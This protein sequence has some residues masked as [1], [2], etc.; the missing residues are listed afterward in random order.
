VGLTLKARIESQ[1]PT[2]SGHWQ[3]RTGQWRNVH[4][5]APE[6]S[7]LPFGELVDVRI[8]DAGPHFLRGELA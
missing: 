4:L 8:V 3:A 7:R 5:R 2:E 1:L 6:G